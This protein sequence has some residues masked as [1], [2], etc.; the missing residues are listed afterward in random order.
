MGM[1]LGSI[2]SL[3]RFSMKAASSW[4]PTS[5]SS[6]RAR[7][8][9][10]SLAMVFRAIAL[11]PCPWRVETVK[12]PPQRADGKIITGDNGPSRHDR[13]KGNLMKS[14]RMPAACLV[15]SSL[16]G[17]TVVSG[18]SRAADEKAREEA[19]YQLGVEAYVYGYPLV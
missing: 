2:R 7:R 5:P 10:S 9:A 12:V 6:A 4:L 1:N 17:L 14:R 19:A 3:Y 13:Q 8:T 11:L 16:M 18:P 15:L